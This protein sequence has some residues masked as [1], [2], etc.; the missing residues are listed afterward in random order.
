MLPA[1]LHL[2]LI[3]LALVST[4]MLLLWVLH[5]RL[6]NASVVDPG[7][8]A[9][10]AI[11]AVTY[12]GLG[13]GY[14]WR[15]WLGAGMA[16]CWGTRLCIHLARRI[17][18]QPEEG[19]YQQLR[20]EWGGNLKAKFL[21]FFEFQALLDVVLSLPFLLTA[22]NSSSTLHAMEYGA[23]AL[24]AAAFIG[25]TAADS[26]LA[27]FKRDLANRGKVCERGLWNYSRHP[28]FFFEWLIW[29]SWALFALA[30]PYGW[31]AL[32]CPALMLYFL[33]RVT[34]IPAT[35]AQALRSRGDAYRRYQ[36]T[37]SAFVPWLKKMGSG[38]VRSES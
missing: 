35:E 37:T 25:E 21:L 38:A 31:L 9:G 23:A 28:N 26:Q 16:I 29:V 27:S 5:L 15:R 14:V 2:V 33:F 18:G 12:A 32:A 6:N 30:S 13:T 24:W 19:R 10:I 36:Q 34:G 17:A 22:L 7:W 11:L 4:M 20:K 8:A 1:T 3:G